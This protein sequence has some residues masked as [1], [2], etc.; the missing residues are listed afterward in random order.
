MSIRIQVEDGI[1]VLRLTGDQRYDD[2]IELGSRLAHY[3]PETVIERLIVDETDM[4]YADPGA[5]LY[6]LQVARR[7]IYQ[8]VA[9]LRSGNSLNTAIVL[10]IARRSGKVK[11]IKVF[12]LKA[13]AIE[14]LLKPTDRTDEEDVSRDRHT[15]NLP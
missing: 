6:A 12:N 9:L 10:L 4:G 14:W 3:A 13:E 11:H 2:M 1:P 7:F 15:T 5:R 8:R